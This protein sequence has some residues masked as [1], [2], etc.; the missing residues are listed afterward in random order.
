MEI[1][2]YFSR[3]FIEYQQVKPTV[4]DT[5][6]AQWNEAE[7]QRSN[8]S[9]PHNR[10]L[11]RHGSLGALPPTGTQN[12]SYLNKTRKSQIAVILRKLGETHDSDRFAQ[13]GEIA[14][15]QKVKENLKQ[16]GQPFSK[17]RVLRQPLK[18]LKPTS[19]QKH[20]QPRV[21]FKFNSLN[22]H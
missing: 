20:M 5:H 4:M 19:N 9:S 1:D 18:L 16:L 6:F 10:H 17:T 12:L 11:I 3:A 2:R 7:H 8:T 15:E 13:T 21:S 14:I 22:Q